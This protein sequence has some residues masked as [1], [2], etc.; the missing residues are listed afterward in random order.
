MI[1]LNHLLK[2]VNDNIIL[3]TI[4]DLESIKLRDRFNS[5]SNLYLNLQGVYTLTI[6]KTRKFGAIKF[7]Q[8]QKNTLHVLFNKRLHTHLA[9]CLLKHVNTT[10]LTS[11]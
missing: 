10:V 3:I 2:D 8:Q 11:S 6:F 4:K 9:L 7:K 1:F 5:L